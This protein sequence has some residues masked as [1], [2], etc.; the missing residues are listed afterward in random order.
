MGMRPDDFNA[1][2]PAEFAY[3][4]FGWSELEQSRVQQAWERE[5]WGVWVQTS[6]QLDQKDRLE[7][8]QM[9][10]FPWDDRV[11]EVIPELTMEERWER[12]QQIKELQ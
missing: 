5:R 4:S 11:I 10:P 6:I 7:I 3:A 12:V 9:F 1:M 2:T 8:T